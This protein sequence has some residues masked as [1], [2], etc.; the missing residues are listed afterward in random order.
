MKLPLLAVCFAAGLAAQ[1]LVLS[2]PSGKVA[3]AVEVSGGRAVYSVSFQGRE[4]I[5]PSALGLGLEGAAR[6]DSNFRLVRSTRS[7]ARDSWKPPYGERAEFPDRYNALTVELREEIPPRR[8]LAIEF[9][10]YDEGAAFRYRVPGQPGVSSFAIG[11][12]LTEFRLAK[13]AFGWETP[14]AQDVYRR[15]A[16]DQM[17]RA[18][19]RP[20]LLE[21]PGGI[22]AAIAEAGVEDYPSMFLTSLRAER[23]SLGAKLM[24]TA[25]VLAPFTSPWRV[26]LLG[27]R[28]GD[29]LEHNYLLQ[30]LSPV[31]RLKSTDW[32]R[33]G[34][35][36]REVTLSTKGGRE[37]VDFAVRNGLQ[38]IEYDAGWYGLEYAEESDATHVNIDP[39]RLNKDTA[40]QGLDLRQVI[41][42]A[43]SKNVGV[44]LYVNRRALER[45]LDAILPLFESWGVAG[46]KYGFVN[47]HTQPWTRWLYDAVGKAAAH[48]LIL[49]IHDEFRPTGMSRTYPNLLTQEGILGNEGLPDATHST[50]LPFTRMLAGAADYTYCWLDPRLKNSWGHQMA[51]SVLLYSP[52]QFVYWYDRP[53]A[54]TQ[55]SVGM[56]WFRNLPTVWDD[57]KVIDGRPGEF[58]AIA[59][60]KGSNWYLGAVTNEEARD[61][62]LPLDMLEANRQYTA[63]IFADGDGSR[64]IRKASKAVRR[65]DVLELALKSR[66][67]AA[68]VLSPNNP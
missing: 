10:A 26:I 4:A 20:F 11:D 16:I 67:G 7:E 33:P 22:W 5:R 39:Q 44:I 24:G 18:S 25:H 57:T 35:V 27:D 64:D 50:I 63:T 45:Q 17:T 51:L 14:I 61:A 6:L 48:R 53:V 43:K 55:E 59:R 15:V 38:Y 56:E 58:A 49:D 31:S 42:Y 23:H 32:I 13:G 40:Y 41:D 30:N 36:L 52:L 19:E 62:K 37:A 2:S 47:V 54:F 3:V 29:L 28:P 46:V 65:G 34:K 1:P 68:V 9:R 21:L 60:R 66:G 12:E 8:T